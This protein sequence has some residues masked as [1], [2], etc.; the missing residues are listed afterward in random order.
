MVKPRKLL[1]RKLKPVR[2]RH[3]PTM[4]ILLRFRLLNRQPKKQKNRP[5][6][7]RMLGQQRRR[8]L[9][10]RLKHLHL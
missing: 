5:L 7:I 3:R 10:L 1:R 4:S 2:I 6:Q 8:L 9:K